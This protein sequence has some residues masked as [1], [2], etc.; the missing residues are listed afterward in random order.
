MIASI[1]SIVF[2]LIL[3]AFFSASETAFSSASK[4]RLKALAEKGGHLAELALKLS[5]DYDHLISTILVGNNIVNI[6]LTAVG[7]VLF[8][9][10][11]GTWGVTISTIVLTLEVLIFGEI[12]PKSIVHEHAE[13]FAQFAAPF[14]WFF[15][16]LL[17]P[18]NALF[19]LWKWFLSRSLGLP[20]APKM[21]QEELLMLV[22]EVQN[23]GSIDQDEGVLL[24][25][26]IKFTEC[27]VEE[28]ITHRVDIE[29]L[30]IDASRKEIADKFIETQFSR[31]L[32]YSENLDNIVGVLT[33][34]D[35]YA[36]AEKPEFSLKDVITPP[37]FVQKTEKI[38]D[39]LKKLQE[40]HSQ[41]AVVLDEFGGTLGIVSMEDILEELVGEIWD[42]HDEAVEKIKE[43]SPGTYSVDC[44]V[45]LDDFQEFFQVKLE[46]DELMLNGFVCE[47]FHKIPQKGDKC[48]V[49]NLEIV[50]SSCSRH[51][52]RRVDVTPLREE[53]TPEKA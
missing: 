5:E 24:R 8:V 46:S 52:V 29:A 3:S 9:R 7:T 41:M 40:S 19:A 38:D 15:K 30:P 50:V 18:V 22:D 33:L 32:V 21:S 26:A 20:E 4:P 28:I 36:N 43:I 23:D 17:Y 13:Q 51:R 39:I 14:L 42:E 44:T 1:L 48:R 31:L 27:K 34:K 47:Q 53:E 37:F 16:W 2:L 12:T 25:N 11:Y 45:S 35:F 10:L 6:A 49:G